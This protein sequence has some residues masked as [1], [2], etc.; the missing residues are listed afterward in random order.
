MQKHW[1]IQ[2]TRCFFHYFTLKT[3]KKKIP[4]INSKAFFQLKEKK[5]PEIEM[6]L[7]HYKPHN[8]ERRLTPTANPIA[9]GNPKK[10]RTKTLEKREEKKQKKWN[11]I[12]F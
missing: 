11:G 6:Q 9:F 1:K 12:G 5:N 7:H 10:L 3:I 2:Q 4:I 8:K